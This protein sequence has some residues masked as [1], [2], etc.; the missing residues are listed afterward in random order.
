MTTLTMQPCECWLRSGSLLLLVWVVSAL[1]L[2]ASGE[3]ATNNLLMPA[4]III[5]VVGFALAYR[6]NPTFRSYVLSLDTGLLIILHSWR[7]L[8]LGFLFLYAHDVLPGLFAWLAGLGDA[9]A[10]AG[11]TLIGIKLLRG[12][13]VSKRVLLTWNSFGLMDFLIAISVGTALRSAWLG[14]EIP[15]DPMAFLPLSL[16]PTLIVPFYMITHLIIFLQLRKSGEG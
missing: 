7:M 5:P 4:L 1:G 9:L 13:E 12:S 8:G 11:A 15:T 6:S 16:I 3:L 10:A 14:S 2:A